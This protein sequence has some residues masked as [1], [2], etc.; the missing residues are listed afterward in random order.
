MRKCNEFETTWAKRALTCASGREDEP[1]E[2]AP[3]LRLSFAGPTSVKGDEEV[4]LPSLPVPF[5]AEGKKNIMV[6]SNYNDYLVLVLFSS[7]LQRPVNLRY[8]LLQPSDCSVQKIH[9]LCLLSVA[10][11]TLRLF[12]FD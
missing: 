2:F 7:A 6:I 8:A 5:L 11:V 9:L 4:E 12:V 1:A 10:H 3:A